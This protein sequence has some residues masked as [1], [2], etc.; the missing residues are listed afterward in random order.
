MI[1]FMI[2]VILIGWILLITGLILKE[3]AL[4][5]IGAI[6]V[7]TLG[8]YTAINGFLS[9]T[10]LATVTFSVISI[11]LGG[12]VLIRGNMELINDGF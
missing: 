11:A 2:I 3:Y 9:M 6:F 12:Y 5:S 7:M 10:N 8:V 4:Y 1:D